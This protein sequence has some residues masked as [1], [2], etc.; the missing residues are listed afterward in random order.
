MCPFGFSQIEVSIPRQDLAKSLFNSVP[1]IYSSISHQFPSL[2]P[3]SNSNASSNVSV[4]FRSYASLISSSNLFTPSNSF[5]ISPN[6]ISS[7]PISFISSLTLSSI[8]SPSQYL[9]TRTPLATFAATKKKYKPVAKK[10]RPT[11]TDL[12]EKFRIVRNIAGNPLA[13]LPVLPTNPTSFVTT[14]RYT[15]ERKAIIDKAHPDDFLWPAERDLMHQFMCIHQDGFA[16][17]DSERGHFREDFF[18]PVDMPTI[19]HKPWVVRNL[20][21]P[22]GIYNQVCKEIQRKIDAKIYEPS[23]SS[24]RSRWFCVVKKDGTSLR[25]VQSLEPL[26][27]VTIAHS[28][29]P[30]IS[31][32]LVE[33]F[34]GRACGAMLDLY[35]GYDKRALAESSR[36]YT[37]FQ[38]PFGALRLTT[39]PMGWT[40]SV[41]IFHDDVTHILREEIPHITVP[42]IDD[43]PIK[44]PRSTYQ[45]EDGNYETIAENPGIRRFVWEHFQGLNRVVQRMK[46][47]G[48]TF[49]GYKSILCSREITVLGHLCTPEGRLPDP[50]RIQKITNWGPLKDL[51]DVRAFLGTLGVCRIF[52]ENFAHRAH[53][54]VKLTRKNVP[55]EYGED[56]ITA[57]EDLKNALCNS[58][59]L[60]PIDYTSKGTVILSVDTSPIAIGYILGQC[61]P[62]S[63]KHRYIARFGSI[64]LNEREARFSQPKLELYGLYRTLRSLRLY[65]IGLRDLIVEVDAK[66]IKGMLANP[67]IAPSASINRWIVSILMFHFQLIHVPGTFHGPDGLSRRKPQPGDPPEPED[68]FEDWIDQVNG[69][70]HMIMTPSHCTTQVPPVTIHLLSSFTNITTDDSDNEND[71]S[72]SPASASDTYAII[73]RSE[74]ARKADDRISLVKKWHSDLKRPLDMKDSEYETFL[75]YCT[76]FFVSSDR[77]WRKDSKGEHKLVIAQ[78]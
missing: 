47:S 38:S 44:G 20:P 77:L 65:L 16:W 28:G 9:R 54:L 39:L 33:Q 14:G 36:D 4:D 76:E 70:P 29:V 6:N 64:T 59:A 52:I 10:I 32:H 71:D 37:T 57:Q 30:P 26:N 8:D 66:Y 78:D 74:A 67:D 11:Y 17:N 41:P 56:Q 49:S 22:P 2:H 34:A 58:P 1:F 53:H 63:P 24:Y 19:P 75:R 21:I 60:R 69:F 72:D 12:P 27:A 42:Y 51:S 31:E 62:D 25:L 55:F 48:G 68:D 46:Y 35:I 73:P 23:N 5:S 15:E 18:P 40:N 3:H 50:S 13:T 43:V 45:D 61:D 7:V